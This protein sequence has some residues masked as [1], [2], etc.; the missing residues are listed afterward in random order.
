MITQNAEINKSTLHTL[1]RFGNL[2][3]LSCSVH[4]S[5]LTGNLYNTKFYP[6]CDWSRNWQK[7]KA[8]TTKRTQQTDVQIQAFKSYR[9]KTSY[10]IKRSGCRCHRRCRRRRQRCL[11]LPLSRLHMCF[12]LLLQTLVY[13]IFSC[14]R[15]MLTL[16]SVWF[17]FDSESIVSFD[18][19][20]SF[21]F[22][23]MQLYAWLMNIIMHSHA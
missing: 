18:V 4:T 22:E 2:L 6:N 7:G 16:F 12:E 20:F 21:C 23:L 1:I 8:T 14:I 3:S 15:L 17:H 5:S 11:L 13:F 9:A 10:T 19:C